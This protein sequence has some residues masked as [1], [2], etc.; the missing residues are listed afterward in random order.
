M[1]ISL[2]SLQTR[3]QLIEAEIDGVRSLYNITQWE[4]DFLKSLKPLA[5]GSQKQLTALARIE[6]KVFGKSETEDILAAHA[7]ETLV[8]ED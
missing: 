3:I 8:H 2:P 5:F 7:G 1:S 4:L 6:I